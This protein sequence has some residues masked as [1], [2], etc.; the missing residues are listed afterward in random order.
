MKKISSAA[1][2]L[3][4]NDISRLPVIEKDSIVGIVERHDVLS[5]LC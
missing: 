3:V 4:H 2:L 5:G 1:E